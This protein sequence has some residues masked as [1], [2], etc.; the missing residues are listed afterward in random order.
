V[1]LFARL[2]GVVNNF[3]QI[4]GPGGPG[5]NNNAGLLE[6]KNSTNTGFV[7]VRGAT[8]VG[9]NDLTTKAYVDT[10]FKPIPCSLQFNGNTA[11][12]SNSATEQW[13][14]VTTSGANATIGQVL[15][16]DGTGVGTVTVL[17]AKAGNE[18]VTTA[19]FTGGTITLNSNQNYVWSGT[20]WVNISPSVAGAIYCIDFAI[21]TGASQSSVT[22]IPTNAIILRC[23]VTITTAYSAGTTIAVGQTGTTNLLQATGDNFPTVID[24]YTA[25]QRT[26]WGGSALPVLVTVG[27]TP[28][29]GVGAV[30]VE[31]TL[32]NS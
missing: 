31:Y 28:S 1:G 6:G 15:W 12:P 25:L 2:A 23:D 32:P 27:G 14:V 26:A 9:D 18:I 13:Y 24:G 4:G 29:A 22:S 30:T 3:F 20:A 16:D 7:V 19:A 8:P 10:I 17:P 21:G 5:W 11:L